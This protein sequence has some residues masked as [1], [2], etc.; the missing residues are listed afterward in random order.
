[1]RRGRGPWLTSPEVPEPPFAAGQQMRFPSTC[2]FSPSP[3]RLAK[4]HLLPTAASVSLK[5][6]GCLLYPHPAMGD[7]GRCWL[8]SKGR[9][10]AGMSAGKARRPELTD[11]FPPHNDTHTH[12]VGRLVPQI[13]GNGP[14]IYLSLTL[15]KLFP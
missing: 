8:G 5:F 13:R 1:M 3:G 9:S 11:M 14:V 7:S 12:G 4:E 6:K 15:R 10:S 2:S